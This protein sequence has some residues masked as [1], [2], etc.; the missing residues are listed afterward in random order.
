MPTGVGNVAILDLATC[1]RDNRPEGYVKTENF[2]RA[3]V[4]IR[5]P[6]VFLDMSWT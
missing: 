5:A 1:L 3:L 2:R 6:R 4:L